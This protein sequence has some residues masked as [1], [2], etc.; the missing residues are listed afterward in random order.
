MSR[1]LVVTA[2]PQVGLPRDSR[3]LGPRVDFEEIAEA[4]GAEIAH[5]EPPTGLASRLERELL[6]GGN[7]RHAW[8]IRRR[9]I[10]S[11]VSLTE[12]VGLPLAFLTPRCAR[13]VLI[14]HNLTT[15][16][17]RAFQRRTRYLQRFDRILVLSHAQEDYLCN[18]AGVAPERVRFV[19][20]K[21]D[22]KFFSPSSRDEGEGYLLSV[23]Q[24]QRDYPTLVEAARE[25]DVPCVIIPSS[26][27]NPADEIVHM[28]LP[29]N[30]SVRR[31]VSFAALRDLYDR[32]SIVAVPLRAGVRYAAGV[33]AVLEGMA[34]QKPL[35]VSTTPGL[36]GYLEDHFTARLVPPGDVSALARTVGELLSD[37]PQARRLADNAR[38]VIEDGRNLDTY[39][40]AVVAAV[41]EVSAI[42]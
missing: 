27:W 36:E 17:R 30:V 25:L 7:W 8:Q 9:P 40:Q 6:R 35:V 13:H 23:G 4:L 42:G 1:A 33:N 14:A 20:D 32:A 41:R 34:M 31:D 16:R 26:L 12:Q 18:E 2:S 39:V 24:E 22:H 10:E 11:F 19:F 15:D 37:R 38:R 5:P 21:V 28:A 3:P 29:A